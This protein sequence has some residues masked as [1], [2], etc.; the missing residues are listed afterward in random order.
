MQ[1]SLCCFVQGVRCVVRGG[2]RPQTNY[3]LVVVHVHV[4]VCSPLCGLCCNL[5]LQSAL[6]LLLALLLH[7]GC[8]VIGAHQA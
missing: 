5:L 1:R 8:G 7:L 3:T 2:I 4:H 6:Q